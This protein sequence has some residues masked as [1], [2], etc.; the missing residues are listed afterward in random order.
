VLWWSEIAFGSL[1]IVALL[2]LS[3]YYGRQQVQTLRH[4][5]GPVGLPDEEIRFERHKAYRRL[6]S[7]FLTLVLAVLLAVLLTY[8]EWPAHQL[9][10]QRAAFNRENAPPF[11]ADETPFLREWAWTWIAFLVV[12]M[13]VVF[14]AAYDMYSTRRY[15]LRQYRKL[16]ADRRAM[17]E[18]QAN[19]L[20]RERNGHDG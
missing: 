9:A 8:Y 11:T 10:E 4:F 3:G 17:I 1:L 2:A 12:L 5:R 20:R 18:R 7:C 13:L 15:A 14:L 16:Q 19:R 6:L